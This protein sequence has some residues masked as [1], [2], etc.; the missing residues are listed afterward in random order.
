MTLPSTAAGTRVSVTANGTAPL[1][2]TEPL[3]PALILAVPMPSPWK[4]LPPLVPSAATELP[5]EQW[6]EDE[7]RVYAHRRWVRKGPL[8][9]RPPAREHRRVPGELHRMLP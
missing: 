1:A 5:P 6:G 3:P 4:L 7:I 8:R 2:S 9:L